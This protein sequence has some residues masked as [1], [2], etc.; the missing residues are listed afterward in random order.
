[1]QSALLFGVIFFV[2]FFGA[3][4]GGHFFIYYSLVKFFG[5]SAK[6]IRIAIAVVIAILALSFIAVSIISH[7]SDTAFVKVAYFSSGM[8]LGV[9]LNL[10]MAFAVAW[11]SVWISNMAGIKLDYKILGMLAV[12]FSIA[13]AGYGVWNAYHPKIKN[14]TVKINNLPE[15]WR[16]KTAVQLSD[17]HLGL[18]WKENFLADVVQKVNAQKP[19]IV[20]ITGDLFDGMDGVLNNLVT[21]LKDIKA[22]DGTYFVTGNHE[23]YLGIS[24]AFEALADTPVKILNDEMVNIDDMQ[25]VGVS[26]PERGTKKNIEETIKNITGFDPKNPSILLYHNP[27]Q[28]AEAKAS[29]VNLQLAG[30][31]H[32]GQLFPIKFIDLLIYGKYYYGLHQDGN[33]SIYTSAG[34]GTWGPTIRTAATPEIVVIH[35]E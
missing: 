17:V 20:F 1:M 33:F 8:W 25:I 12:I 19:D 22:S 23:T 30:H 35:F 11:L 3:V 27:R 24:K 13:Y 26:F 9:A 15:A 7:S 5:I 18:I 28:V 10:L 34:V 6:N 14:I 31:T 32:K 2:S 4:I 16:G 21:P 29:G